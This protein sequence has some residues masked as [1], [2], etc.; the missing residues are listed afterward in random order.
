MP[1]PF[2][3]QKEAEYSRGVNR[4]GLLSWLRISVGCSGMGF[5]GYLV[6]LCIAP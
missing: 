6:I 3:G 2:T 4:I 5:R 1:Q